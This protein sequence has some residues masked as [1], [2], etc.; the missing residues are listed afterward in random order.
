MAT[1]PLTGPGNPS[2]PAFQEAVDAFRARLAVDGAT[3]ARMS[4]AAR[5]RAFGVAGLAQLGLVQDV[6]K[7]LEKSVA[8]GE[9]FA[10][11]KKRIGAQVKAAWAGTVKN[12]GHRLET[13]YRTNLATAYSRGTW[14]QLQDPLTRRVRPYVLSQVQKDER[15]S[16]ICRKI[17][18]VVLPADHPWWLTHWSP[19]HHRCRRVQSALTERQAKARGVTALPPPVAPAAG[20]GAA[21]GSP[22][23]A[24]TPDASDAPVPL[25]AAYRAKVAAGPPPL[26][27]DER[28]PRGPVR[29]EDAA[30]VEAELP[31]LAAILGD[32]LR[33]DG[34]KERLPPALLEKIEK[35]VTDIHLS[36]LPLRLL[37]RSGKVGEAIAAAPPQ[38]DGMSWD[39]IGGVFFTQGNLREVLV[40]G[41]VGEGGITVIHEVGHALD[42]AS[43]VLESDSPAWRK[44][45]DDFMASGAPVTRVPHYNDAVNG[46]SESF[47]EAFAVLWSVGGGDYG[48]QLVAQQFGEAVAKY[49]AHE[50]GAQKWSER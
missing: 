38:A 15:N 20:F 28:L 22:G 18:T 5:S 14:T 3:W 43:G 37:G 19:L 27:L 7:A 32:K 9:T 30:L 48:R 31:Q 47:A 16:D 34:A 1:S 8:D 6:W 25:Q 50:Y 12:P 41:S 10:D 45:W 40:S 29:G 13:I 39:A 33:V 23:D 2:G 46:R 24:W 21:P 35:A 26:A 17:G 4:A 36:P 11:F 42:D 49:M 44:A